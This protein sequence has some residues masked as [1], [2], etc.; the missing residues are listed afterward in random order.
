MTWLHGT[1]GLIVVFFVGAWI[2][3]KFPQT[4]LLVRV[5]G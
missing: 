3:T 5:I 2:G 4:N 1:I